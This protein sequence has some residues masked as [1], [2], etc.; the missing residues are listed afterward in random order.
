MDIIYSNHTRTYIM[1]RLVIWI[2][3][4][5]MLML[6]VDRRNIF[7]NNLKCR[8][9]STR[10]MD[11]RKWDYIRIKKEVRLGLEVGS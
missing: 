9:K 3:I 6:M 7:L 11:G 5:I 2:L 8:Y 1:K 4:F 10:I